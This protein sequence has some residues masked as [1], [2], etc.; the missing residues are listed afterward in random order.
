MK[1]F[2]LVLAL[3]SMFVT[4]LAGPALAVSWTYR[5]GGTLE[6]WPASTAGRTHI[7]AKGDHRHDV[8]GE[9]DWVGYPADGMW[10]PSTIPW[11]VTVA[12]FS[13]FN[14]TGQSY[15]YPNSYGYCL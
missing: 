1:R 4:V 14:Q 9:S 6:C 7:Y 10:R 3:M 11:T 2:V 15:S 12:G 5:E 13:L 8:A